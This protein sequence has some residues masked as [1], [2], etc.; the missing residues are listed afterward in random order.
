MYWWQKFFDENYVK[1]Y[2]ELE[3]RSSRE[4][5]SILRMMNL[6]SK[7]RILDLCCGY[8]RHSIELA[9]KGFAVTGYDL[10]DF[11][12]KKAK[13]DAAALGLKIRFI[14]GDMRKL[15][16]KER[17]DAVVNVFTSFGYFEN[18]R[19]DL[20]VLKGV[21]KAL[22]KDGLFLLDLINRENLIR[23]FQRRTWRPNRDFIVLEDNFL[24][25]F[26]SRWESTRTLIFENGKRAQHS[27]S[28]RLFS[29]AE[30]L[31]LLNRAGFVLESVY[32]DFDLMEYSL[33]SPRMIL[34]SRKK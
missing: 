8:G 23:G 11:F 25:L 6:E 14:K 32:G 27:F 21:C 7:A 9:Q 31:D 19:D 22:K 1:V 29:F 26:T 33:D 5:D 16:F 24:D 13:K 12:L 28:L 20:K 30:M 34:I 10:S 18:E 3:R 17:F 4:V 2:Q 15:P